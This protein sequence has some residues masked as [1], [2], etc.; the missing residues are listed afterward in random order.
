L[1]TVSDK[2]AVEGAFRAPGEPGD[3]ERITAL[4]EKL[5]LV[6]DQM[7]QWSARAHSAKA[8]D[9]A[10]Q[11]MHIHAQLLERPI[12]QMEDYLERWIAF[13]HDL[14]RLLAEAEETPQPLQFDMSLKLTIDD[15]V[16][17]TFKAEVARM[18]R[19]RLGRGSRSAPSA[20]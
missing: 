13:A 10:A 11:L 2:D 14:P 19:A 8:A 20:A 9:D 16:L 3:T 1:D 15:T 12:Q 4:A 6:Y 7:L 17:E 5:I 18:R